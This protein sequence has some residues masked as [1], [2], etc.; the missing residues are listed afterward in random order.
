MWDDKITLNSAF[1]LKPSKHF[2]L[3]KYKNYIHVYLHQTTLNKILN[4]FVLSVSPSIFHPPEKKDM[5]DGSIY[6]VLNF[7]EV[8]RRYLLPKNNHKPLLYDRLY[9]SCKLIVTIC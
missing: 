1:S 8:I 3:T 6:V 5:A 9:F 7:E 4:I 2:S